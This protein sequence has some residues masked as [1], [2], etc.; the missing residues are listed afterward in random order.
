MSEANSDRLEPHKVFPYTLGITK[1]F[2]WI[3]WPEDVMMVAIIKAMELHGE[4][5]NMTR[6]YSSAVVGEINRKR[7][8]LRSGRET[9]DSP[10]AQLSVSMPLKEFEGITL[11]DVIPSK[12]LD[13]E[14]ETILREELDNLLILASNDERIALKVREAMGYSHEELSEE[15]GI[16]EHNIRLRLSSTSVTREGAQTICV[17]CRKPRN[18]N[19]EFLCF[20]CRV[21]TEFDSLPVRKVSKGGTNSKRP[22]LRR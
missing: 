9:L 18:I 5:W 4:E 11:G 22:W 19:E 13:P 10:Q 3:E 17:S 21:D 8:L 1:H 16:S 15:I 12:D 7:R 2:P 14:E 20:D 6:W